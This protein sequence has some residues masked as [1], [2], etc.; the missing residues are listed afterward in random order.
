MEYNGRIGEVNAHTNT[1]KRLQNSFESVN[2]IEK[3]LLTSI[4]L[5]IN[6]FKQ[7]SPISIESI[8][9]LTDMDTYEL[10]IIVNGNDQS[11]KDYLGQQTDIKLIL[12]EENNSIAERLNLGMKIAKGDSLLFI[13]NEV[14]VTRNWLCNLTRALFGEK[15][16]FAVIPASNINCGEEC[17]YSDNDGLQI[18]A[19]KYNSLNE[20][21]W[22][23]IIRNDGSCLLTKRSII[24]KIGEFDIRFT[25]TKFVYDD[26]FFRI[27]AAGGTVLLCSNAFVH[28]SVE[29]QE[30]IDL[31]NNQI[32]FHQKWGI[33]LNFPKF[34]IDNEFQEKSVLFL[35]QSCSANLAY[36]KSNFPE[37][38][39]WGVSSEK[40]SFLYDENYYTSTLNFFMFMEKNFRKRQFDLVLIN[41]VISD[42]SELKEMAAFISFYCA[43]TGYVLL[44]V[45]KKSI[46][47]ERLDELS[48]FFDLEDETEDDYIISIYPYAVNG[49]LLRNMLMKLVENEDEAY[50]FFS[51]IFLEK[52]C[53]IYHFVAIFRRYKD[54]RL[55]ISNLAKIAEHVGDKNSEMNL[56]HLAFQVDP[57]REDNIVGFVKTLSENQNFEQAITI[58]NSY[59]RQSKKLIELKKEIEKKFDLQKNKF[60]NSYTVSIAVDVLQVAAKVKSYLYKEKQE[61]YYSASTSKNYPPMLMKPP[62]EYIGILEN[63]FLVG[64]TR[65]IFDEKGK[66]YHD[67]LFV[68]KFDKAYR[69]RL[70]QNLKKTNKGDFTL[71]G[72]IN[73]KKP[74]K[75]KRG[76]LISCEYDYS[77]GHWMLECMPKIIFAMSKMNVDNVPFLVGSDVA[78]YFLDLILE[79]CSGKPLS[80]IKLEKGFIYEVEELTYPSDLSYMPEKENGTLLYGKDYHLSQYWLKMVQKKLR[81]DLNSEV[82]CA[83]KVYI[84]RK[85]FYTRKLLNEV[86]IEKFLKKLGFEIIDF[87]SCSHEERKS[88]LKDA[89][90]VISPSGSGDLNLL[91][92]REGTVHISLVSDIYCEIYKYSPQDEIFGLKCMLVSGNRVYREDTIHDDYL[93]DIN[94]LAET[95]KIAEE[96]VIEK[97][98]RSI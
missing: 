65:Y 31:K 2:I 18:F 26:Y 61:P 67:D 15:N 36:L 5:L 60:S 6:K 62:E 89:T 82:Q 78:G 91:Y 76:I 34:I 83:R 93:I 52:N 42:F 85:R 38:N 69:P 80:I 35:G 90:I 14:I 33:D 24:E 50:E 46:N 13:N 49:I 48:Y 95:I 27:R 21:K 43:Y 87:T 70:R 44:R 19:S 39:L 23:T 51:K 32:L 29:G 56:W 81:G 94:K 73:G 97:T 16:T 22:R 10:I 28:Q 86:D 84:S 75:I 64:G 9:K 41:G 66:L 68:N 17:N 74:E 20:N 92:C 79:L 63:V 58:I 7:L 77:Y 71:S 96:V 8:L 40:N 88:L 98:A 25:K 57:S 11:A 1:D 4:I 37:I 47:A 72:Y 3:K 59:E 12:C 55:A 30:T 53:S 45:S 54:T